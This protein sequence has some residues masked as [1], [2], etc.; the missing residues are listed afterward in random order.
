VSYREHLNERLADV[1]HMIAKLERMQEEQPE[2]FAVDLSLSQW[3]QIR[4][5]IENDIQA[6]DEHCR[7]EALERIADESMREAYRDGD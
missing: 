7:D 1:N 4:D 5:E 3:Q 2:S 6:Y